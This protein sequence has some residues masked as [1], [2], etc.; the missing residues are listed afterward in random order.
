MS[1]ANEQLAQKS[2]DSEPER[3][4]IE[5]WPFV[6]RYCAGDDG[7]M[8]MSCLIVKSCRQKKA[9]LSDGLYS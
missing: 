7:E 1:G 9:H 8:R 3:V 6:E 4:G 2:K 5:V